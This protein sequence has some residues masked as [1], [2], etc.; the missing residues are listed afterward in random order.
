MSRP[1]PFYVGPEV[2]ANDVKNMNSVE[3]NKFAEALCEDNMGSK[4]M[5]L[6]QAI[7]QEKILNE[8]YNGN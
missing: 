2:T 1:D 8:D 4:L 3:L 7:N 5:F 6:L